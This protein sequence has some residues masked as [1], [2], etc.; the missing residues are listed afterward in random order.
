MRSYCHHVP[1]P[2]YVLIIPN[3]CLLVPGS[4]KARTYSSRDLRAMVQS[5]F[6]KKDKDADKVYDDIIQCVED[7]KKV[8]PSS[9]PPPHCP[10]G[11]L[12]RL[13]HSPPPRCPLRHRSLFRP[14]RH[15][16]VLSAAPLARPR[17]VGPPPCA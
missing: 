10:R 8:C 4:V 12:G 16:Y 9:L 17:R 15:C 11:R 5:V 13:V 14:L 2:V 7:Q 3:L 1:V 6:K